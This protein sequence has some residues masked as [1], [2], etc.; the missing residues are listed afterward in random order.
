MLRSHLVER[1]STKAK[2]IN[3]K[4]KENGKELE[5]GKERKKEEMGREN[6]RDRF[7]H[8]GFDDTALLAKA[9]VN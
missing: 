5:K 4:E 6:G 3:G 9:R 7:S 8:R 2:R 1:L